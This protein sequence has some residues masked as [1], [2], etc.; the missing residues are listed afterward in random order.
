MNETTRQAVEDPV[1]KVLR[2]GQ[3]V[4]MANHTILMRR[5]GSEVFI[6]DSASL[7]VTKPEACAG[8]CWCSGM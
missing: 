7:S 6:D 8:W 1:E 4:G 5:D 2:L 3:I